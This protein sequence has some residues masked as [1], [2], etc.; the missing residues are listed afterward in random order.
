MTKRTTS[1]TAD[2][3][4]RDRGGADLR[5]LATGSTLTFAGTIAKGIF[6]FA[7]VLVV[8]R[9]LGPTGS[10][11]FFQATALFLIL[12]AVE[13]GADTGL[14][15]FVSRLET[16]GR[17]GEV[18]SLLRIATLPVFALASA[19]GAG[20]FLLAPWLARVLFQG[21]DVGTA[22]TS[23]RLLAPFLPLSALSD[24]LVGGTRGFG[25]VV[26]YVAVESVGK[27]LLRPILVALALALGASSVGVL[28]AWALPIAIG[29]PIVGLWVV[30]LLRRAEAS[31][32][33]RPAA[34]PDGRPIGREFWRFCIPQGFAAFLQTC[35]RSLDVLLVGA[36]R[37]TAEAG[38]YAA[39]SRTVLF[40]Q[41]A[42]E[43]I[44][45]AIAPQISALLA[46]GNDSRAKTVY[47][48]ATWWLVLV[49]WPVYLSLAVFAPTVMSIFG[50]GFVSGQDALLVLSLG[51]LVS[52]GTGNVSTVLLM[53]GRSGAVLFNTAAAL[54]VDVLVNIAL[55]PRLGILGAAIAW[56]A[57][58]ATGES[59]ALW[60]VR[61]HL[62]IDPFG[63][64]FLV[65]GVGSFVCYG[66]LGWIART[67]FGTSVSVML[68]S[69]VVSSGAYIALLYRFR[70]ML[71]LGALWHV[72][73]R[74][75]HR[76]SGSTAAIT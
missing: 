45:I 38:V 64:G 58:I 41:F 70:A 19:I 17:Q 48:V 5:T 23:L 52:I 2:P 25:T 66:G 68:L 33:A 15:R 34:P 47:R 42:I 13:M 55:I 10:G 36:M 11:L 29:M 7:L 72:L 21:V 18:R 4:D 53:S 30:V 22:T 54:A 26:P 61:R 43:S 60:Q 49:S 20:I 57:S 69:V 37:T 71:Q 39:V 65:A 76:S 16:L 1:A 35:V 32:P 63:P 31:H 62:H 44:R 51:M 59:L 73:S 75:F 8:T 14:V 46:G 3:A 40:G 12:S 74:P 28:A 6:N 27:P 24:V 67:I 50:A 56:V 9:G